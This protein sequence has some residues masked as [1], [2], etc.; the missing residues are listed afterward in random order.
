[1]DGNTGSGRRADALRTHDGRM[2]DT[3]VDVRPMWMELSTYT[4]CR[5]V[6]QRIMF[7]RGTVGGMIPTD[8]STNTNTGAG[9]T[10]TAP[11]T[12][13]TVSMAAALTE[14]KRAMTQECTALADDLGKSLLFGMTT[15]LTLQG[16]ALPERCDLDASLKHITVSKRNHRKRNQG[17]H[18]HVWKQC[19]SQAHVKIN[20]RVYALAP[21]LVWAQLAVHV[22]L[23]SLIAL[24]E[25]II[26]ANPDTFDASQFTAFATDAPRFMGKTRC[27]TAS[28]Y[29]QNNVLSPS[30]SKGRLTLIAHGI[31][32]PETNYTVPN[33]A[34]SS[35]KASMS[36]DMAWVEFQ[37]G[38]EYDG[39]QHRTD[40]A[41]WRRD[42]EKREYLRRQ[43][44]III[45]ITADDLA[46]EQR[47][48]E[49]AFA[50]A[51]ALTER[52]AQFEFTVRPNA[53]FE[54]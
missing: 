32:C 46:N 2:T 52:G 11:P 38:V 15:A 14:R 41:Q 5:F 54:L 40:K 37:V 33:A 30:E 35:S 34:F 18:C 42:Q 9:S 12:N 26:A 45:C 36:L 20:A 43:G 29:I 8:T 10:N 17:I 39:D 47:R 25:S 24:A 16:I 31:P 49:F 51:Q 50:V 27:M 21:I 7:N 1:M 22:P 28:A 13:G 6:L 53:L 23:Y 44:W 19:N 4:H 48:A 3:H